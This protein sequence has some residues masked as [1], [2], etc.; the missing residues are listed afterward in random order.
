MQ[1]ISRYFSLEALASYSAIGLIVIA[2]IAFNLFTDSPPDEKDLI[3]VQGEIVVIDPNF[4]FIKYGD[5]QV[6]ITYEC[7]CNYYWK[8]KNLSSSKYLQAQVTG[9]SGKYEAWRLTLD[10]QMILNRMDTSNSPIF[11]GLLTILSLIFIGI[12]VANKI[13]LKKLE[14]LYR[15]IFEKVAQIENPE[16]SVEE[17]IAI[18]D[19]L[20]ASDDDRLIFSL[21][22]LGTLNNLPEALQIK[23]GDALGYFL[24]KYDDPPEFYEDILRSLQPAVKTAALARFGNQETIAS[25]AVI[26]NN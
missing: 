8:E 18:V 4:A 10:D 14:K 7:L 23:I 6:K 15:D 13:K 24:A 12:I 17:R 22:D 26:T 19:G 20:V 11:I 9:S 21:S 3:N 5:E 16:L 2:V 1:F 25:D